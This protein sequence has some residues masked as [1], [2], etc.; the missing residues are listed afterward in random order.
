MSKAEKNISLTASLFSGFRYK[1]NSGR[2]VRSCTSWTVAVLLF[3]GGWTLAQH[4]PDDLP[5]LT[6]NVRNLL[7]LVFLVP[8]AWVSFRISQYPRFADFLIAVEAEMMKVSWPKRD[9]LY[10]STIVVI[11]TMVFLGVYLVFCDIVWQELLNLI[12]VL[13]MNG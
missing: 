10:R 13:R 6:N 5:W 1:K 9:E 3:C 12:G 8:I 7:P 11:V 4:L 2:W